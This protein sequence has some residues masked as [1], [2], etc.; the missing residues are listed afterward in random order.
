[1]SL[2]RFLKEKLRRF[3]LNGEAAALCVSDLEGRSRKGP[4]SSQGP[5]RG[6]QPDVSSDQAGVCRGQSQ[7]PPCR[8]GFIKRQ[9]EQLRLQSTGQGTK[10]S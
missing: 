6:C 2:V 7:H 10:Q 5:A 9:V 3:Q 4:L 1:M 8:E